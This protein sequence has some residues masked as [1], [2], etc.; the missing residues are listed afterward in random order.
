MYYLPG[1]NIDII[2]ENLSRKFKLILEYMVK[3]RP[4]FSTSRR[5]IAGRIRMGIQSEKEWKRSLTGSPS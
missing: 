5:L 1:I 4:C 3:R 2:F